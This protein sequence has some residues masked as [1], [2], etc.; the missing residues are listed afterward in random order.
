MRRFVRFRLALFATLFLC[1]RHP[2]VAQKPAALLDRLHEAAEATTLD[3]PGATPFHVKLSVEIFPQYGRA[4]DKGTVEMWWNGPDEDRIVYDL[5]QYHATIA[6]TATGMLR[7]GKAAEVPYIVDHMLAQFLHPVPPAMKE[8][9]FDLTP[10]KVAIGKIKMDCIFTV[11]SH[12]KPINSIGSTFCF[13]DQTQLRVVQENPDQYNLRQQ[14]GTL[15]KLQVPAALDYTYLH[16]GVATARID[17]LSR[18]KMPYKE[19]LETANLVPVP[20]PVRLPSHSLDKS[21]LH[22]Q[23][24]IYP[25]EA[26]SHRTTGTVLL[27]VIVGVNGKVRS[28]SLI[29]SPDD[30]LTG[31]AIDAVSRWVYSPYLV[32]GV[33]T[34]VDTT[35]ATIYSMQ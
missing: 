25:A 12:A 15:G 27:H 28:L 24:P 7:T 26:K 18:Q 3:A 5:S 10:T 14:I 35:V 6:R 29:G 13:D 34:E 22:Q 31:S 19:A 1:F 21:L 32:N 4:A 9:D 23:Q 30:S 11:P 33:P 20:E 16:K 2:S 8:S 17:A